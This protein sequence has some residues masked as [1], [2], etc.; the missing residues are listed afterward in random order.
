MNRFAAV[1]LTLA[2][3]GVAA[4][5]L[6]SATAAGSAA[7][8]QRLVIEAK[9]VAGPGGGAFVLT[10]QGAGA[11]E[12]D[13][14]TF[15]GSVTQTSVVRSGQEVTIFTATSTFAGKLGTLVIRERIDDVAAGSGYR[16]GT[17]TWSVLGAKATG[18]YA[19]LSGSGRSAY[20][21]TPQHRVLFRYEGFLTTS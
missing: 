15:T 17:G 2:L 6:G 5:V 10:P 11:L 20:S 9:K 1:P 12:R 3:V 13:S 14:G 16:V 19:G 7:S 4:L 21:V 18:Q 8:K